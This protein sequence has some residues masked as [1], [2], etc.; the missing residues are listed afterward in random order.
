M[1]L[2]TLN[3]NQT[4]RLLGVE[5]STLTEYARLGLPRKRA[6]SGGQHEYLA[7]LAILWI[8]GHRAARQ[9]RLPSMD[10][11]KTMLY[12]LTAEYRETGFAAWKKAAQDIANAAGANDVEFTEAVGY[13]KGPGLLP[14]SRG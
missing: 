12:A 13:L 14:W 4:A 10:P 7:P 11:L 3:H 6:P 5:R 8:A 2:P 9:H 1:T